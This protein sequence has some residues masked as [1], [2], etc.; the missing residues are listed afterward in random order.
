MKN[1]RYEYLRFPCR[2][3]LLF[4]IVLSEYAWTQPS[5]HM[6]FWK[7]SDGLA[8]SS[9]HSVTVAP[10]G[11]TR[12]NFSGLDKWKFTRSD[13]LLFSHRL[14]QSPWSSFSSENH[15][16]FSNLPAGIHT[17]EVRA[18]DRNGN[19]DPSPAAFVFTVLLPWYKA[20]G[21]LLIAISGSIL[22]LVLLSLA[23]MRHIRLEKLVFRRTADLREAC[24][25]AEEANRAKSEFV[26]SMSHEI[27]T[28]MNAIIGFTRTLLSADL[29]AKHREYIENV[30]TAAD[31]LL[32]LLNDILDYSKIEAGKLDLETI[33]FDLRKTLDE[34]CDLLAPK[35][36]EKDIELSCLMY[37]DVPTRLRGDPIRLRQI[38]LNLAGNAIKF[39]SAGEVAIR[40]SRVEE[41]E[42]TAKIR[43]EVT[44]T[45]IGIPRDR[46]DRLFQSFSQIDPYITRKYGGSG[47]GLIISKKLIDLLGGEIGVESEE[48][49][50]SRFWFTV[51]FEKPLV[52]NEDQF[53]FPM[54]FQTQRILIACD[55]TTNRLALHEQLCSWGCN[56]DEAPSAE[57]V[58]DAL[59]QAAAAENAFRIVLMDISSPECNREELGRRIKN[60]PILH[61]T[62]LV[63]L[64]SKDL[65]GEEEDRLRRLGFSAFLTK[66]M[67]RSKLYDCLITLVNNNNTVS[68]IAP[69]LPA[70]RRQTPGER[71]LQDI[72]IL[73]AEDNEVNQEVALLM[74]EEIGFKA[75][76]AVNGL[77]AIQA[78][79]TRPYDL[80]FM[81]VQMPEMDGFEATRIIRDKNSAVKNHEIPI[82][83]I[84][85]HAMKGDRE[86][87]LE[88]GMNDY[89]TKPINPDQLAAT[90]EKI[91]ACPC[92]RASKPSAETDTSDHAS[93]AGKELLRSLSENED[94]YRQ[95]LNKFLEV[96]PARLEKLKE[97]IA[98]QDHEQIEEM[99]HS[100]KG[101]CASVGA[102]RMSTIAAE[103]EKMG[104]IKTLENAVQLFSLLK[105]EYERVDQSMKNAIGSDSE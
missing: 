100:I 85:A 20:T 93:F 23:A 75:D 97:Y 35:A 50:G 32:N 13:R 33:D 94:I 25:R 62:L 11:E 90:L 39:T 24:L 65:S 81:D 18:M 37:H 14:D 57:T 68:P 101:S 95:V 21:F 55:T 36:R 53:P 28:P 84:T 59:R 7:G 105:E 71:Q 15:A 99:A 67:R 104:R 63:L 1:Q 44:D 77:E 96:T 98:N 86:K 80:V 69:A 38:F 19:I 10:G 58:W 27:R 64:T 74:L 29:D 22:I 88:A 102:N 6:R 76:V 48:G 49:K 46:M 5:L 87:C 89:I 26:A 16:V 31:S 43:A 45:G 78:L 83:A 30:S 4:I 61:N 47:L 82:I 34:V 12:L 72:R 52:R 54:D 103:L 73:L 17:F 2:V 41:N 60:D 9:S 92:K 51:C 70:S 56:F 42:E 40:I 91:L 3:F 8:E 79:A 66:P